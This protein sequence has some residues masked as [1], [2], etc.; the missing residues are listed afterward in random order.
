MQHEMVLVLLLAHQAAITL[1][2]KKTR[3]MLLREVCQGLLRAVADAMAGLPAIR[4][5]RNLACFANVC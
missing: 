2:W 5:Q 1:Y 3:K 4:V